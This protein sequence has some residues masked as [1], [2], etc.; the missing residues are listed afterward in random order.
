[1]SKPVSAV[2]KDV[3][4]LDWIQRNN[5]TTPRVGKRMFSFCGTPEYMAPEIYIQDGSGT[6]G[7][8][9]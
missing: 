1:M 7:F 3:F 2:K 4:D 5:L 9:S 8:L 6:D